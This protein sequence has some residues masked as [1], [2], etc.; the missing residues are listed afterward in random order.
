MANK[1]QNFKFVWNRLTMLLVILISLLLCWLTYTFVDQKRYDYFS[2]LIYLPFLPI[3][4]LWRLKSMANSILSNSLSNDELRRLSVTIAQKK[5]IYFLVGL[6]NILAGI[7][8]IVLFLYGSAGSMFSAIITFSTW[9][10]V[11]TIVLCWKEDAHY[12]EMSQ[13]LA[14]RNTKRERKN[15]LLS[16]LAN[17]GKVKL[18]T[19]QIR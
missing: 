1:L 19:K 4:Y 3:G 8:S 9:F 13:Y 12:S 2:L 7:I 11:V 5:R 16:E 6:L 17:S 14:E 10:A 15:E 18:P